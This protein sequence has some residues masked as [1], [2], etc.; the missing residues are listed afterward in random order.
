MKIISFLMPGRNKL[1]SEVRHLRPLLAGVFLL[2]TLLG[3][4]EAEELTSCIKLTP[5]SKVAVFTEI[6]AGFDAFEQNH[7]PQWDIYRRDDFTIHD[8]FNV[9]YDTQGVGPCVPDCT[10][11]S[12]EYHEFL[13]WSEDATYAWVISADGSSSTT[14]VPQVSSRYHIWRT[15]CNGTWETVD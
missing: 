15:D 6:K 8:Q 5:Q 10:P 3:R 11:R 12:F 2:F 7:L 4:L 13:S 14:P 9:T 1:T